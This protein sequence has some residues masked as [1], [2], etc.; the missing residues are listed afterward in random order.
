M[1]PL[2]GLLKI[3]TLS[4]ALLASTA[5]V[6]TVA[7]PDVAYAG[8]GNGKGG[9]GNGNGADKGNSGK[10]G[11]ASDNGK[12]AKSK[13]KSKSSDSK[14]KAKRTSGNPL[15]ALGDMF[16][17]KRDEPKVKRASK[18]KSVAKAKAPVASSAP[19]QR[20]NPLAQALGVHPSELGA[21]NAAN[22]SPNALANASPNSRVGKLAIYA[23]EVEVSRAIEA[24][25]LTAQE[26]LDSLD[27]PERSG[28]EID[29]AIADAGT[30]KS[31]RQDELDGL[32]ADLDAAGGADPD[33][34]AQIETATADIA[35]LDDEIAALEQERVD[36]EAYDA[37]AEDVASL[38]EDLA[39]QEATQR[40]ALEAA[41]N[42][43][44]TDAVE[45]AV[46]S[47]LGID[48]QPDAESGDVVDVLVEDETASLD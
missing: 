2:T 28:A 25:L 29:L 24:D 10:S 9:N 22:A 8:N 3:S 39:T 26:T 44:V 40:T 15:K 36:G 30:A 48:Q 11:A 5:I 7:T 33:I 34:E 19:K 37:A 45:A 47:L 6:A 1:K 38:E 20:G 17:K 35:A 46:Q 42:K 18:T 32:L 13:S 14:T 16:K 4:V 31:T 27:A 12:G 41:A 23:G 43:E 21:L